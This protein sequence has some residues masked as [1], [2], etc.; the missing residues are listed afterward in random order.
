MSIRSHWCEYDKE[1]RKYIKNR[2]KS[3]CIICNNKGAMQ[4]A[5]IFLSRASGGKGCEKNGVILCVKCH[6]ILDNPIGIKENEESKKIK[7]YCEEYLIEKEEI[8]DIKEL[9][10]SLKYDKINNVINE[11]KE[12]K[13]IAP[14]E[15]IKKCK[16]CKML[17]KMTSNSTIPSY[18]CKYRKIRLNKTTKKCDKFKEK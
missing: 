15:Y 17:V 2:D 11:Y 8:K 12:E 13:K 4:I 10:K 14:K 9:K 6:R 7:K 3:K 5:H 18:Y 1:T 16:D